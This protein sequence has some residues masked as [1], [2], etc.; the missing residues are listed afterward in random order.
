MPKAAFT[1]TWSAASDTYEWSAEPGGEVLSLVPD[2]PA[3]FAW[4]AEQSTF[5]FHGQTGEPH[6]GVDRR[7]AVDHPAAAWTRQRG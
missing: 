2:S 5:A 3:W 4:L 6:G 7:L 1:L